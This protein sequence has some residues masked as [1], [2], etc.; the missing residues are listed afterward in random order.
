MKA[1][2]TFSK[3]S[4]DALLQMGTAD[5]IKMVAVWFRIVLSEGISSEVTQH[6]LAQ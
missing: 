6:S 1:P 2:P 3:H 4:Y 5:L